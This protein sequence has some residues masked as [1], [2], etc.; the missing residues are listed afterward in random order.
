M[1]TI[2]LNQFVTGGTKQSHQVMEHYCLCRCNATLGRSER[3]LIWTVATDE[4]WP[5][6]ER[7][8]SVR[9]R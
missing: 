2:L 9:M 8:S 5:R 3:L 1:K 4:F 7:D 6:V